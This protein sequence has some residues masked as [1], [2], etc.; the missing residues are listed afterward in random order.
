MT[1]SE[2]LIHSTIRIVCKT[3]NS[4]SCGTGFFFQFSTD[5][6][7]AMIPVIVTNKHVVENA[8]SGQLIFSLCDAEKNYL[9]G[10]TH[11]YSINNFKQ[12]WIFHPD[13]NVDLCVFPIHQFYKEYKPTPYNLY[14]VY[15]T[16]ED[17][18]TEDEIKGYAHIEDVTIVGYPDGLWDSVNNLPLV[19][20]GITAS[21]LHYDFNGTPNFVVDAAIF[22]GSSGSPVFLY[23]NGYFSGS[24]GLILGT[25]AKLVGIN[26]AVYLHPITG[27]ITEIDSKETALGKTASKMPNGLGI[28]IHSRKLLDFKSLL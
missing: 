27:E 6:P 16:E 8:I 7:G 18:P 13:A 22:G 9:P 23:N 5:T 28:V 20:K 21:S 2:A 26:R 11:T 1:T 25:R 24:K 14:M 4:I 15:I 10:K 12:A 17:I 3:E 19:R